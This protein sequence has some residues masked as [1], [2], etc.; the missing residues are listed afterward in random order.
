MEFRLHIGGRMKDLTKGKPVPL[1]IR[2]AIPIFFGNI[3][4]ILYSL[5]DTRIV[6]ELLGGESLA[7]VGS[8]N[9]V[10][11]L[12][13]GFLFGLTNGFAIIVARKFG[14]KKEE[15]LRRSV[16]ATLVL[17]LATS[18]LLT[19]L[20]SIFLYPLLE[21][22]NTPKE[23]I[24][25]AYSYIRIIFL[26]MTISMI[27][28]I[29]SSVLRAIGDTL[30]PL[31]FL[32]IAV[33]IN[34]VLDYV[35]IEFTTLGVKGAAYATLISQ[36]LSGVLCIIYIY[37]KYPFL[38]LKKKDFILDKN[39]VK[40][41]FQIG[42]SMGFMSSLV[43][44][45]SVALQ[46][47]INTFGEETIVAHTGARKLTELF[48]LMFST[49]GTAMATFAGQNLGAGKI[50]RVKYGLRKAILIGWIWSGLVVLVTYTC[51]P[52]LIRLVTATKTQEI[53]DTATLYLRVNTVFYFVAALITIIRNTMQGI[54]ETKIPVVS[55]MIEL[56]GK[57]LIVIFLTP[58][59]DY[60]GVI[61]AE[62][63]IWFLMVI[64]LIVRII[65]TPI[66]K[67]KPNSIT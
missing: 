59:L 28:N 37:K 61:I 1:I 23:L 38:H 8:T 10:N 2:F 4:Q 12:I 54:G 13:V 64:P 43:S 14:A 60:M 30:T 9:S 26:G 62:P 55:S 36:F 32:C 51:A 44:L 45:G 49:L 57:V 48:M 18:L 29:C 35:L 6:G 3:F 46:S 7:A 27:Y 39:S 31:F 58:R 34:A 53:I 42:L 65:T 33:V 50:D 11:A 67:E 22:L 16:A 52:M 56:V 41:M 47:S 25:E 19:I 17:G 40:G 5:V 63:I 66:L 20:S 24:Q 15:E 21:A